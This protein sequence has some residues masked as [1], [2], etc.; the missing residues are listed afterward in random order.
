VSEKNLDCRFLRNQTLNEVFRIRSLDSK[1]DN[2]KPVLSEAEYLK[3]K[4]RMDGQGD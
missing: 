2:W 1:S 4:I 3:S